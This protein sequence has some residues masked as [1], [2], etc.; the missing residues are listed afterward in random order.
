[1]MLKENVLDLSHFAYVHASTF[2]MGDDYG[3]PPRCTVDDG[4]VTFSQEFLGKPLPPFYGDHCG[5]GKKVVDR[6]DEGTSFSPAEHVFV[7][8]IV[9]PAPAAG[10]RSEFFVRFHHMTTPETPRSH[11]Y[12][13]VMA[14]DHRRFRGMCS[15]SRRSDMNCVPQ[16]AER[17]FM[18]SL[19][20]GRVLMNSAGNVFED[21]A[22]F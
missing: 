9:N 20:Q 1:M 8:R 14:R 7:A 15:R 2:E 19:A 4:R 17:P 3:A 6:Y 22:H 16:R 18:E 10:E 13:W 21:G 5:L 12:W 11:H